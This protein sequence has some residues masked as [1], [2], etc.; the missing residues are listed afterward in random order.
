MLLSLLIVVGALAL[1]AGAA[2]GGY[3]LFSADATAPGP[4][5]ARDVVADVEA[6]QMLEAHRQALETTVRA[7]WDL[8]LEPMARDDRAVSKVGGAAYWPEGR[9]YP[10]DGNGN[11]LALLAQV[12]F[13]EIEGAPAGYPRTGLLQFFIAADDYYGANFDGPMSMQALARQ[14]GFRVVYWPQPSPVAALAV[15][16]VAGGDLL[17]FT[18]EQPRRIRFV[19]GREAIGANDVG[20]PAVLGRDLHELAAEQARRQGLDEDALSEALYERLQR[21]GHK[22][23]GH[24]D[25]TQSDPRTVGDDY[26]L[27]LQLDT[28]ESMMWGDSGIANFFIPAQD[29]ARGDF[30]RVAYHWDCY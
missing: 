20:L 12:D 22:L 26:V 19:P 14:K 25:F 17:P 5:P 13:A 15:P 3:R 8:R 10:R 30:S 28:D 9:D 29:L 16:S 1:L 2:Y 7:K 27:L 11:P 24:P 6:E 18:P 21:T 23:G 4:L